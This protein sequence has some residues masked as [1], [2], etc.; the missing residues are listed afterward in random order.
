[1]DKV[2]DLLFHIFERLNKRENA[3]SKFHLIF[4]LVL[5]WTQIERKGI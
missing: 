1:M 5:F 4:A 3:K 2:V